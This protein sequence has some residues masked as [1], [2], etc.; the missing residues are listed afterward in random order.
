MI[1][2]DDPSKWVELRTRR[3]SPPPIPRWNR[4]RPHLSYCPR[5]DPKLSR[6]FPSAVRSGPQEI[7]QAYQ[8]AIKTFPQ[9]NG[10]TIEQISP[11]G[12]DADI[13]IG[14]FHLSGQ[15]PNGPTKLDGRYT[16]V[17]VREAGT[18]KIRLLTAVPIAPPAQAAR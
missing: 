11:L 10:Q 13:R 1:P 16:A 8:N 4:E 6:R 17:D 9:H 12:S 18:W 5:V 7:E 3:W 14:E 15:G 2:V